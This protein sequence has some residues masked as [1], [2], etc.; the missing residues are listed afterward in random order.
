MSNESIYHLTNTQPLINTVK[1]RQ[2]RFLGHILRMPEEEPCRRY[3]LYIPTHGRRRPG[4]QRTSYLT[5][6]QKLF[7]DAENDLNQDAIASLAADR[8]AWRKFVVACSAAEWMNEW[9]M[10]LFRIPTH[11]HNTNSYEPIR[12][13]Q[14]SQNRLI[15]IHRNSLKHISQS[16][17]FGFSKNIGHDQIWYE[18]SVVFKAVQWLFMIKE[19]RSCKLCYHGYIVHSLVKT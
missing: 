6:L 5:Y 19:R 12:F 15:N 11:H 17:F 18:N 8:Y 7:G 3:A 14:T 4:R 10:Y 16:A 13:L 1:Q 9:M 2:L